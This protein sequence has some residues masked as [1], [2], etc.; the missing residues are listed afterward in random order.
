MWSRWWIREHAKEFLSSQQPVR[1][2]VG[3][4]P[5]FTI[6]ENLLQLFDFG[7]HTVAAALIV[8]WYATEPIVFSLAVTVRWW[9]R[10]WISGVSGCYWS[11]I[12][13]IFWFLDTRSTLHIVIETVCKVIS[14][15]TD[16]HIRWHSHY[17]VCKSTWS[18][19]H[20]WTSR[21]DHCIACWNPHYTDCWCLFGYP[22]CDVVG[23][24]RVTVISHSHILR[25]FKT[26]TSVGKLVDPH[27]TDNLTQH[28]LHCLLAPIL[29]CLLVLLLRGC[30]TQITVIVSCSDN[31]PSF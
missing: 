5:G 3:W 13:I 22:I 23:H 27:H 4:C 28:R 24:G 15:I 2:W 6:R 14:Q 19:L 25:S 18:F 20:C 12:T 29:Y 10:R 31:F 9:V 1:W 11:R 26:A 7:A 21:S 17:I 16:T 30:W 8:H